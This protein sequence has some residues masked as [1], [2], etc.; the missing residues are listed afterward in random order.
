MRPCLLVGVAFSRRERDGSKSLDELGRLA[1]SAGLSVAG[2]L[3]QRRPAPDPAYFV[4]LGK[5]SEIE[6]A[7]NEAGAELVVFDHELSP[8]QERN[9]EEIIAADCIDRTRL[10]LDIFSQRARTREGKLQVELAD[11]AYRL[12]RLAGSR[13]DLSRLGG[14]LFT[15]GPGETKL[16]VDRRTLRRRMLEIRQELAGVSRHRSLQRQRRQEAPIAVCALVGYTNAGKS[17]LL[18]ALAGADVAAEDRLF[19]TLD[20]TTRRINLP[21]GEEALLTDTV[22]FIHKLP[23]QLV[24]AFR[25]T[26]EEVTEADLLLHVIDASHPQ[27]EEQAAAVTQVLAELGAANKP[28]LP[29]FNK[30]DL[31]TA[32]QDL[33]PVRAML[34]PG[35][36]A[37][38]LLGTGL[39][40]VLEAISAALAQ[41]R[42]RA[43]FFVPWDKQAVLGMIHGKARVTKETHLRDGV[44]IEAEISPVWA[45]R[46]RKRLRL[47]R[48]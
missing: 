9:L 45:Q 8:V 44:E 17:T 15:R 31:V 19:S 2:R 46:I 26:L 16:E 5:A 14:G 41:S 1:V 18:N 34:P 10:I 38:A 39:S 27:A 4:G 40:A 24:A 35:P 25:A 23:H 12:P 43:S 21:G 3:S 47:R 42:E 11:L 37:S 48:D 32:E 29:V 6:A 7:R 36:S 30:L 13:E 20:P 22:G 33:G 28:I